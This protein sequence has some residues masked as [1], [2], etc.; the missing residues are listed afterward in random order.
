MGFVGNI[1]TYRYTLDRG[2]TQLDVMPGA[3]TEDFVVAPS[4]V[5]SERRAKTMIRCAA[6]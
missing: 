4:G 6:L 3:Q 5:T 1:G 2:L